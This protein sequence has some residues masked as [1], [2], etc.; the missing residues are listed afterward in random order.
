MAGFTAR[1]LADRLGGE[2]HGPGDLTLTG[3]QELDAARPGELSFIG[4][5][6]Y[7]ARW[8][9][10]EASAA[11]VSE[12]V[13]VS[14]GEGRALIVVPD[15]DLAMRQALELFAEPVPRPEAGIHRSAIVDPTVEVGE[16]VA[17]GP[18]CHV[19]ADAVIGDGTVLH[20]SV[21]I[22]RGTRLG[23][24]CE[25]WPGV[26]IRERCGI[27]DRF[28]A[29]PNVVIGSDGFGY[30]PAE[31]ER[32]PHMAKIPQIGR[33]EIGDDVELG[34][35]TCVD[36]GKFAATTIGDGCKLD[37]LVQVA[38]N[39]R[40]GRHVTIAAS[41]ALGGSV[42]IEGWALLGGGVIVRDHV[43]IGEGAQIAGGAGVGKDVPAGE[44]YAG[45]PAKPAKQMFREWHALSKL[46]D[47]VKQMRSR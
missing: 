47:L 28:I 2:L 22:G 33:V 4:D 18:F 16:D 20:G 29:H 17:I 3:L 44:Q 43:K 25:L 27:G 13:E 12:G 15:A 10:S 26:V 32:G 30:R 7:A 8:P 11:L 31:G 39:C 1:A 41:S 42:T 34:A 14:A 24:G 37:N 23:A 38:H 19:G 9:E 6:R 21:T 36:R 45:A 35:G 40:L 5:G 46:P